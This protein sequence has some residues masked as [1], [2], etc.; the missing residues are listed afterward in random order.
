VLPSPLPWLTVFQPGLPSPFTKK[1][2]ATGTDTPIGALWPFTSGYSVWAGGCDQADPSKA[3]GSRPPS[4]PLTAGVTESIDVLL[5][6]V[7]VRVVDSLGTPVA[8]AEVRATPVS[9][10]NCQTGEGLLNLGTADAAG[11]LKTSLPAG[12]YTLSVVGRTADGGT[13]PVTPS[14]LP[15]DTATEQLVAVS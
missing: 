11:E 12:A 1:F 10:L 15:L 8:G 3:G 7:T 4:I 6:P 2:A 14:S 9:T 13:W 5:A